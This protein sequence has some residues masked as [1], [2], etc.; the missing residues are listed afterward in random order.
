MTSRFVVTTV[1]LILSA[2]MF[3]AAARAQGSPAPP[4]AQATAAIYLDPERGLTIDQLV[5]MAIDHAPRLQASRER[6]GVARGNQMQ[7]GAH[8]NPRLDV[9]GAQQIAGVDDR[10]RV[11]FNWPL[12]LFRI[13]ALI[14]A[15]QR[16]LTVSE[17]ASHEAE[18]QLATSVRIAVGRLM[19]A[20]RQ[21]DV[22]EQ[23]VASARAMLR[24]I[25]QS[26][27][28]GAVRRSSAIR[29]TSK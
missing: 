4:L 3:P 25:Q 24:L 14:L 7:A 26:V 13:D 2:A 1:A 9:E 6:I 29:R 10:L 22:T 18:W 5:D 8:A 28:I 11:T 21:L 12:Q 19:S 27:D 15:A 17:L 23:Q 20:V 16:A